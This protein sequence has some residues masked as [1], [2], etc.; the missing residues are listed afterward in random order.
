MGFLPAKDSEA[1]KKN[2]SDLEDL[3]NFRNQEMGDQRKHTEAIYGIYGWWHDG[4]IHMDKI[5]DIY[6]NQQYDFGSET[7]VRPLPRK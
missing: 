5:M 6:C 1:D 2:G 4:D 3:G 7:G